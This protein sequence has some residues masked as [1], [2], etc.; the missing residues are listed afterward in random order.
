MDEIVDIVD[1][2]DNV[3]GQGSKLDCHANKILHRGSAVLI[4]KDDSFQ[5]ILIQK[6]SMQKLMNPGYFAFTGGH[7]A[8]GETY[9]EAA[10]RE[11]QEEMFHERILP[12]TMEFKELFKVKK[13]TDNDYEFMTVYM[14][15]YDGE[16]SLDPKEVEQFHFEKIQEL[17]KK[18]KSNP[19]QYTG[20]CILLLEEYN[21]RLG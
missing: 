20:T 7:L 17:T 4:F 18:V 3:I 15:V 5:D 2:N 19:E 11:L 14:V 1:E 13:Y 21:K 10:K 9:L 6:R 16:F 12:E 8:A